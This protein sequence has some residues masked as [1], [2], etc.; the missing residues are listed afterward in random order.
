MQYISGDHLQHQELNYE[1]ELSNA[2]TTCGAGHLI[3]AQ[4]GTDSPPAVHIHNMQG[5]HLHTFNHQELGLSGDEQLYGVMC[6][7]DGVLHIAVGKKFEK[8]LFAL[9][10]LHAYTVRHHTCVN[11]LHHTFYKYFHLLS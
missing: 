6:D 3:V 1:P 2:I 11:N 10:S 7:Q 8:D 5:H 9:T 4:W